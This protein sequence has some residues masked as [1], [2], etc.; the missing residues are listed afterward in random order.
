M[1]DNITDVYII[2]VRFRQN[3]LFDFRIFYN[4]PIFWQLMLRISLINVAKM[5]LKYFRL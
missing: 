4:I 5:L 2:F 3:N 1:Q